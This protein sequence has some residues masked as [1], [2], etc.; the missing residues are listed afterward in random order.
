MRIATWNVN[1]IR[2]RMEQIKRLLD[3]QNLDVLCMQEVKIAEDIF[4]H[5]FFEQLGYGH[6]AVVSQ[7]ANHG[8][9]IVSRLPFDADWRQVFWDKDDKRHVAVRFGDLMLHNFYMPAGG[10][11]PDTDVNEK[12]A[13]KLG[14]YDHLIDW[15]PENHKASEKVLFMGDFNIAPLETDVW[16]HKKLVKSVGHSPGETER[17]SKLKQALDFV[18]LPRRDLSDD[19][20]LFTWWGY[21]YPL[22][23]A[24]DYGWRLD[25]AFATQP[26]NQDIRDVQVL[27]D[28]RSWEKPSDHIPIIVEL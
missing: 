6:R 25:H 2:P 27:K 9:A 24:K 22:A 4:P 7:K 17:W 10:D 3:E 1:G 5:D 14:F 26:L 19:Q 12:F 20:S 16:N 23:F 8:V 18:D 11:K 21:R 13:H 15:T 28:T